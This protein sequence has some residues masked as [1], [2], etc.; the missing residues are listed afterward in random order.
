MFKH[1]TGILAE[2]FQHKLVLIV[3]GQQVLAEKMDGM[4]PRFDNVEHR[5]DNLDVKVDA[6]NHRLDN[7]DVKVDNIEEK[8]GAVAADL[9]EH[10]ADTEIHKGYE[11][12]GR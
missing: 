1:H 7:L 3:E 8:L 4:E 9:T 6:T 11:V 12:S 10:R 5:L 2:D